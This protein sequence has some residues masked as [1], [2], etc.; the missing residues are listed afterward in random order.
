MHDLPPPKKD[1]LPRMTLR[2]PSKEVGYQTY[3]P[4]YTPG[5]RRRAFDSE[6]LSSHLSGFHSFASTPHTD[7]SRLLPAIPMNNVVPTGIV[8]DETQQPSLSSSL[9]CEYGIVL[10]FIAL[11]PS[12]QY[13][14]KGNEKRKRLTCDEQRV[15]G[16]I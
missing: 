1:I 8:T 7:S 16:G 15:R 14:K 5:R 13:T 6:F 3:I 4:E 11:V 2:Y 10:S 12:A 9:A